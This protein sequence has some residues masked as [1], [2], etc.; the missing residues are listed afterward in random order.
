MWK[1][2]ALD[3]SLFT[4]GSAIGYHVI[5]SPS[6][7]LWKGMFTT[8]NIEALQDNISPEMTSL[9]KLCDSSVYSS[10]HAIVNTIIV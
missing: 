2:C 1:R 5:S 3:Y 6:S 7:F 9:L 8:L 10:L 4:V